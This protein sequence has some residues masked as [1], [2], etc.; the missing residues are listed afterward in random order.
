[1]EEWSRRYQDVIAATAK[2]GAIAKVPITKLYDQYQQAQELFLQ[3][4]GNSRIRQ[5][6][7]IDQAYQ[8]AKDIYERLRY[9]ANRI[10]TFD[11]KGKAITAEELLKPLQTTTEKLAKLVSTNQFTN[12]AQSINPKVVKAQQQLDSLDATSRTTFKEINDLNQEIYFLK[13]QRRGTIKKEKMLAKKQQLLEET[14]Q[15]MKAV[16]EDLKDFK[17]GEE[18]YQQIQQLKTTTE[19]LKGAIAS[20]Q[21]Q[22]STVNQQLSKLI[23]QQQI[24]GG[25]L[26]QRAINLSDEIDRLQL[27]RTDL[28]KQVSNYYKQVQTL[29]AEI[30]TLRNSESSL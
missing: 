27:Q 24:L 2:P 5:S 20:T 7:T 13:Q 1:M 29:Q 25:G 18:T 10:P 17:L 30:G 11:I 8:D 21:S 3:Q 12:P 22:L 23:E 15:Q 26:S 6:Q 28:V 9:D 4:L 19:Q 14:K 16:G